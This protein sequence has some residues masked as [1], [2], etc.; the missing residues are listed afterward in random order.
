MRVS[1][2]WCLGLLPVLLQTGSAWGELPPLIPREVLFGHPD[3]LS[4]QISPDGSRLAYLAPDEGV[5]NIW[6]RTIGRDDDRPVTKDRGRGIQRY[7][8]AADNAHLLYSCDCL[9]EES[10]RVYAVDLNTHKERDLTPFEGVHA[11]VIAIEQKFPNE[12]LLAINKR[13]PQLHDIY[14]ADLSTGKL[15]L[16]A[17]NDKGFAGWVAD[18]DFHLRAG[19]TVTPDGGTALLVRDT[20]D[21]SWRTLTT[22]PA[23]DC[24]GSGPIGFTPNGGSM[25]IISS[26]GSDTSQLRIIDLQTGSEKTIASDDFVDVSDVIVHP[27]TRVL[28]AVGFTRDRLHWQV[29]DPS[30]VDDFAAIKQTRRGDFGIIN[31]DHQDEVWL[32]YFMTDSG[33]TYYYAYDRRSKEARFLFTH[34][35]AAEGLRL[36][37]VEPIEFNAR[38]GL[39]IHGYLTTPLGVPPKNLPTVLKVHEGPWYRDKWGCCAEVQWLANRGYAVLQVNF[40]GSRGYGKKFLNAGNREWGGKMQD[41][42]ID[43]VNWVIEQGVADSK[44]VAIY[45][46][47]YG[48]YATL[49][50][51]TQTP[52]VFCC[53]VDISGPSNLVSWMEY[54]PPYWQA[55]GPIL[56]DRVGHPQK[57]A[58]FLKSRSPFFKADR[59]I[60]PL[61]IVQ[62]AND[63]HVQKAETLEIVKTLQA[64]GKTVEYIE[65]PDEGHG[66]SHHPNRL[67]FFARAEKFLAEHLGGRFEPV[68]SAD[69]KKE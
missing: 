7:F 28:Q 6:V 47:S 11:W 53:G 45:G 13:V 27:T 33:P 69:P 62:G 68:A 40:R 21:S 31:R 30:I 4:P 63:R 41:D 66:I 35:R 43:G 14:R 61:L 52:D 38:D 34:R 49:V 1:T 18:G 50:G 24:F 39:T 16:E 12:I 22:W 65:Y 58:E 57:D 44:R 42:L 20:V 37:H 2:G 5:M 46:A 67:D 51:L 26:V 56:W 10:R 29:L 59:I 48:G 55:Y 25:Y 23:E 3:K 32:V 19:V 8:W 64:A 54:I 60:K 9:A 36:P 17:R 15:T